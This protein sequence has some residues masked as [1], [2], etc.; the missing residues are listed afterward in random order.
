VPA[1]ATNGSAVYKLKLKRNAAAGTYVTG[2]AAT[3]EGTSL[4][5]GTQ[6]SVQ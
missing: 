4:S 3:I 2:S 1:T 6:F 5:A